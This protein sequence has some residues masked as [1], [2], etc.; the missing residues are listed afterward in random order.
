MF[1]L[2][3]L[4]VYDNIK[5]EAFMSEVKSVEN[6]D[7]LSEFVR[8]CCCYCFALPLEKNNQREDLA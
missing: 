5:N 2:K 4:Q 3:V 8:V 7:E 6:C 1:S